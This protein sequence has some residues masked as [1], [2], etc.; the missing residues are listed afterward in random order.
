M[1]VSSLTQEGPGIEHRL[2]ALAACSLPI[3]PS[4]LVIYLFIFLKKKK[5]LWDHCHNQFLE[6]YYLVAVTSCSPQASLLASVGDGTEPADFIQTES[7]PALWCMASLA[8]YHVTLPYMLE[9][10]TKSLQVLRQA[11]A[12][13]CSPSL[14]P[15][16]LG[17]SQQELST[18]PQCK[19]R[20]FSLSIHQSVENVFFFWSTQTD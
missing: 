6:F 12:A 5:E 1:W 7:P 16:E 15:P 20:S 4:D 17:T 3:K 8:R 18:S 2:S 14:V 9:I 10:K 13:L 11:P 19:G